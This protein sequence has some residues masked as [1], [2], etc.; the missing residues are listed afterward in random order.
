MWQRT[1]VLKGASDRRPLCL[2]VKQK[3]ELNQFSARTEEEHGARYKARYIWLLA[4]AS[5]KFARAE[6]QNVQQDWHAYASQY[7]TRA[8]RHAAQ[9]DD[10]HAVHGVMKPSGST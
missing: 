1:Q 2:P 5:S 7:A 8:R 9:H 3:R 4:A 6:L 10:M